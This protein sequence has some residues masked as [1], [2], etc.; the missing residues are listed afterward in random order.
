MIEN[1]LGRILC[2]L[3]KRWQLSRIKISLHA[4]RDNPL[5]IIRGL[6]KNL[7]STGRG[8]GSLIHYRLWKHMALFTKLVACHSIHK[9]N[10][11]RFRFAKYCKLLLLLDFIF[12]FKLHKSAHSKVDLSWKIG[13]HLTTFMAFR[14]MLLLLSSSE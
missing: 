9:W 10:S 14:R 3:L 6:T 12:I 1:W 7:E 11:M 5:C 8:L 4:G 2:Y 13:D